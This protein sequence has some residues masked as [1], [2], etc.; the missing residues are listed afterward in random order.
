MALLHRAQLETFE[1]ELHKASN[2]KW[3]SACSVEDLENM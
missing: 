2:D 3:T 1:S